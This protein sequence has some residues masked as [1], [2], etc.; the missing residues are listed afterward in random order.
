[1]TWLNTDNTD[2]IDTLRQELEDAISVLGY[3]ACVASGYQAQQLRGMVDELQQML[4]V[5][6]QRRRSQ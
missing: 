6:P 4:D 2:N 3:A 1:M 5:L